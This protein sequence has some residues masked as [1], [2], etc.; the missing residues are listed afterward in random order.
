[1]L[2]GLLGAYPLRGSQCH[3][4]LHQVEGDI[5]HFVTVSSEVRASELGEG[6]FP[7]LVLCDSRP[8]FFIGSAQKFEDFEDLI[9]LGVAWQEGLSV[10]HLI[11]DA[12]HTVHVNW[13]GVLLSSQ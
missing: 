12:S 9:N 5:I 13:D 2:E 7:E 3:Q 8:T 4:L 1:M 10:L 6:V 11:E